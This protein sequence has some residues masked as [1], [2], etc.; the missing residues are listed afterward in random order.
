[1][2]MRYS[3]GLGCGSGTWVGARVEGS[4]TKEGIR[5]AFIDDMLLLLF[6]TR[7]LVLQV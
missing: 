2:R 7:R 6:G 5:I 3:L 1:M 4:G